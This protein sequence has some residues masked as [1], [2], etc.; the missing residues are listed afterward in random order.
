MTHRNSCQQN[1]IWVSCSI[2]F[3]LK[4][5]QELNF[6]VSSDLGRELLS[7]VTEVAVGIAQRCD[8]R[9]FSI[10]EVRKKSLPNSGLDSK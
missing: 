2:R 6:W 8:L 1:E 7:L 3:T 10:L 5:R 9:Y 4:Y